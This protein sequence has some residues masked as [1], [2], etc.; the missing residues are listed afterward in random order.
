MLYHPSTKIR[1]EGNS[2][3]GNA[4]RRDRRMD[5]VNRVEQLYLLISNIK[6]FREKE[7]ENREFFPQFEEHGTD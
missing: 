4:L 5:G 7:K 6:S 3:V 1:L 2:S